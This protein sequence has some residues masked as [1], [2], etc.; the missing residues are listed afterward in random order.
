MQNTRM[1]KPSPSF[2]FLLTIILYT[3]SLLVQSMVTLARCIFF[4]I[5][6]TNWSRRVIFMNLKSKSKYRIALKGI[7]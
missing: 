2:D 5:Q 3:K 1:L 7:L 6:S 4:Q